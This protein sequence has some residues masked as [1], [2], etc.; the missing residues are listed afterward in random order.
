MKGNKRT[1]RRFAGIACAAA[2]AL[3]LIIAG[4]WASDAGDMAGNESRRLAESALMDGISA[5]YAVHGVYP[6]TYDE[7]AAWA[8]LAIDTDRYIIAYDAFA[9]NIRPEAAVIERSAP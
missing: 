8:G 4:F 6:A 2:L 7:L 1:G 5:Y 3:S 9:S